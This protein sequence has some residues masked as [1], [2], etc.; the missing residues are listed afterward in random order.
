MP[1]FSPNQA[2]RPA[3]GERGRKRERS[4]SP[5]RTLVLEGW[6]GAA[7]VVDQRKLQQQR[8]KAMG[9]ALKTDSYLRESDPYDSAYRFLDLKTQL[10]LDGWG[11]LVRR[12]KGQDAG[13]YDL[14]RLVAQLLD[15]TNAPQLGFLD[16]D[17]C[18]SK[19]AD[20]LHSVQ[21][22]DKAVV[23]ALLGH[24]GH[25]ALHRVLMATDTTMWSSFASDLENAH[26]HEEARQVLERYLEHKVVREFASSHPQ[27]PRLHYDDPAHSDC[28]VESFDPRLAHQAVWEQFEQIFRSEAV[29][30]AV[31]DWCV[32]NAE[33][34]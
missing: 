4:L 6:R 34:P 20:V 16:F 14:W 25:G 28:F 30:T 24:N 17:A 1:S 21:R 29:F 5:L 26:D 18:A 2:Q 10:V 33:Q 9:V 12:I 22:L 11:E 13:K 32:A 3:F 7:G 27:F 19:C 15:Q 31:V 8:S 23:A